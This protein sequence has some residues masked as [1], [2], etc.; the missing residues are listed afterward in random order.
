MP[1]PYVANLA[2]EN[3][4][5]RQRLER[6]ERAQ[7]AQDVIVARLHHTLFDPTLDPGPKLVEAA[8][9]THAAM[10]GGADELTVDQLAEATGR[11]ARQTQRYRAQLEDLGRLRVVAQPGK[12]NRYRPADVRPVK[13]GDWRR[14]QDPALT[15]AAARERRWRRIARAAEAARFRGPQATY[16]VACEPEDLEQ[17]DHLQN[18]P[19]GARAPFG[20]AARLTARA[21]ARSASAARRSAARTGGVTDDTPRPFRSR[22][23]EEAPSGGEATG[24]RDGLAAGLRTAGRTTP[25]ET[26]HGPGFERCPASLRARVAALSNAAGTPP[27]AAGDDSMPSPAPAP[28]DDERTPRA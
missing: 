18:P 10:Y 5:L 26:D 3:Y 2:A 13:P 21:R 12:A 22:A 7:E 28:S 23:H 8:R 1:T 24:L 4:E 20:T 15:P 16:A 14:R 17:R 9:L 11:S 6:L 27:G 25:A 19:R